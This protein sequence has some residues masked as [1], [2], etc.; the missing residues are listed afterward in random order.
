MK[1]GRRIISV[2][3]SIIMV[4]T[5]VSP[6]AGAVSVENE[7]LTAIESYFESDVATAT[8]QRAAD[9]FDTM[10]TANL[11]VSEIA[12]I[13]EKED[14]TL[15]Y[16]FE[17]SSTTE[18]VIPIQKNGGTLFK[19]TD[20]DK[21]NELF[22]AENGDVYLDNNEVDAIYDNLPVNSSES[23][24]NVTRAPYIIWTDECPYGVPSEYSYIHD[25]VSVEAIHLGQQIIDLT[26]T[27]YCN[28]LSTFLFTSIAASV[29]IS[30][31]E[32]ALHEMVDV[33]P[34]SDEISGYVYAMYHNSTNDITV[35][36][37][38]DYQLDVEKNLGTV[39][40]EPDYEGY[41]STIEVYAY[42]EYWW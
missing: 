29:L 8:L 34:Y 33:A 19:I 22:I 38:D 37:T 9:G 4:F 14:G 36:E 41:A 24:Y 30:A 32:P 10:G 28:I 39:F 20:G 25:T 18:E 42:V 26:I 27:V 40:T 1:K 12:S 15:A 2:C 31:A 5:I 16:Y 7:R 23:F 13:R 21:Y 17:Y 3:L 6:V 35:I 11:P